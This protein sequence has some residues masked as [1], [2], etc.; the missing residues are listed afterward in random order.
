MIR[1]ARNFGSYC[2]GCGS[3]ALTLGLSSSSYATE[4]LEVLSEKSKEKTWTAQ[5]AI[6]IGST[7]SHQKESNFRSDIKI[8]AETAYSLTKKPIRWSPIK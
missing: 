4:P 3:L 1:T 7:T 2:K 6:Q 8:K 5:T